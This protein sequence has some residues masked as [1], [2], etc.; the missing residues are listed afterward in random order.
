MVS[1]E[2]FIPGERAY[3]TQMTGGCMGPRTRLDAVKK[4]NNLSSTGTRIPTYVAQPVAA[5]IPTALSLKGL[6]Q[7]TKSLSECSHCSGRDS[8][9]LPPEHKR[10]TLPLEPAC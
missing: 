7:L 5:A 6:R 9:Q 4:K 3:V 10:E 2:Q 1:L 8:N